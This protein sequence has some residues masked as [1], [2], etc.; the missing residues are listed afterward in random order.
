MLMFGAKA[1]AD[2]TAAVRR[3]PRRVLLEFAEGCS[4]WDMVEGSHGWEDSRLLASMRCYP[5][6]V[7]FSAERRS[8]F[9]G[10]VDF[11][12][13]GLAA[14]IDVADGMF[15]TSRFVVPLRAFS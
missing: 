2:V 12:G 8:S 7:K 14:R 10:V 6:P 13:S 3:K 9:L 5:W 11:L 15:S 4:W 1:A